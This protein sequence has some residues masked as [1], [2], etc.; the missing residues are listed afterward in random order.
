MET[1]EITG[2]EEMLRILTSPDHRDGC[3]F[4]ELVLDPKCFGRTAENIVALSYLFR[5]GR[6]KLVG[7]DGWAPTRFGEILV[8][9]APHE[10][11]RSDADDEGGASI[12]FVSSLSMREWK[13]MRAATP[14]HRC[15]MR[16]G[17][18]QLD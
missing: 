6:V 10:D 12:Q 13:E 16:G 4:P 7:R 3:P 1:D 9:A 2:G 8:H 11:S 18:P 14:E 17:R 15:L 5:G